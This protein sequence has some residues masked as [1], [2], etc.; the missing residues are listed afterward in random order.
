MDDF[1]D[2]MLLAEEGTNS[3]WLITDVNGSIL[4]M[5]MAPPFNFEGTSTGTCL[6]WH[7]SY[8]QLSSLEIGDSLDG[9]QGCFDLS[10]SIEIIRT[11]YGGGVISTEDPTSVCSGDGLADLGYLCQDYHGEGY[12]DPGLVGA[13][14]TG[15]NIPTEEEFVAHYCKHVGRAAIKNWTFYLA[16]NMFRSAGIIQGVYKRGLDG[17]AS[18]AKALQ[19]EHMARQR[20]ERAVALLNTAGLV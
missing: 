8:D 13:D 5:P 11:Q 7:L 10:N 6:I 3:Q 1:V 20:S 4:E 12:D 2:L 16:Y 17:N 19:Y 14:L 15:L 18:S 9:L